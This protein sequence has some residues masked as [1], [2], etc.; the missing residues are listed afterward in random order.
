[1]KMIEYIDFALGRMQAE[2]FKITGPRRAVIEL[3]AKSTKALNPYEMKA[4]LEK[5]KVDI[6]VVTVYR[7]LET[8]EK[9]ALVHKILAFNSYIACNTREDETHDGEENCHHYLLCSKCHKVEEFEGEDLSKL[10]EKVARE[11]KYQINSHYLE[12]IGLCADCQK[13]GKG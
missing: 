7:V 6:D 1:M 13:I 8:L 5:Q 10:E 4:I 12:F 3:L 11:T 2:K 9:L